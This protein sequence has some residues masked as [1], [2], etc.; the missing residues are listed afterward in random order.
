L[1]CGRRSLKHENMTAAER[2]SQ[3]ATI[4]NIC[5]AV[6]SSLA[7]ICRRPAPSR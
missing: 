4:A 2:T 7:F 3:Y 6:R 5:G 1:F